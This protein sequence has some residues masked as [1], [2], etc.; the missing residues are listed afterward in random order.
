MTI[1]HPRRSAG[2]VQRPRG[3]DRTGRSQTSAVEEAVSRR[4][5]EMGVDVEAPAKAERLRAAQL[6]VAAFR[7]DLSA[8]D[9]ARITR[10]D[11]D[12]YDEMGLP[13]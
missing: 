9:V 2:S 6:V 8:D 13:R 7:A 4:L 12:L 3:R 11:E 5:A 1:G 10:A